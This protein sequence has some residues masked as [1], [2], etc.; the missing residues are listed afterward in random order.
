MSYE[1]GWLQRRDRGAGPT[2][3]MTPEPAEAL[4]E[5][6]GKRTLVEHGRGAA[7]DPAGTPTPTVGKRTLV[8]DVRGAAAHGVSG[9]SVALPYLDQIQ[10]SFGR[11]DVGHVRA[12]VGGAAA[13]G[14]AAMG[15]D[16][17]AMGDHVAFAGAPDLHTAAHEAAH[18]VQQRGGVQLRGGVG[19]VGDAYEQ[20]ADAVADLVVQGKSS[21]ALLDRHAG[22]GGP[23]GA[24]GA[25]AIQR[26]AFVKGTQVLNSDEVAVDKVAT[27]VTDDLVRNYDSKEELQNHAA[28]Q[29]D[30]LGNLNGGPANG[31]WLRFFP[32]GT[33]VLGESHELVPLDP[34][35]A[36]VGSRSFI[37]ER[38]ATDD[39]V[40]GS[41][42]EEVY[43]ADNAGR[44]ASFGIQD[45]PDK[46][47]Y[48]AEPL[49]PKFGFVLI[50]A[51]G[52]FDKSKA[53]SGL[54]SP[55]YAG[56]PYQRYLK[57]AWAHAVGCKVDVAKALE[58]KQKVPP[59]L[60]LMV[61]AV[62]TTRAALD[63]FIPGL[64]VDGYLGDSIVAAS[65]LGASGVASVEKARLDALLDAL[66][67]FTTA[68]VDAVVEYAATSGKS[69][70]DEQGQKKFSGPT[71]QE[72]KKGLF[73]DWRNSE[74]AKT[75]LA[76]AKGGIR[77]AGMGRKH[78]EAMIEKGLPDHTHPFD[79]VE[80]DLAAFQVETEKLR[81]K[82]V[83]Q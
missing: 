33:N 45:E 9:P 47:K 54:K 66:L 20:H 4:R 16:A 46:K 22:L 50:D 34:V 68:Y 81:Q 67:V 14:A 79:M 77:Y 12:H 82:A 74:F 2:D 57:M 72:D 53:L 7:H 51:I 5:T 80:K 17:F 60:V 59:K 52:Y 76:A 3:G 37:H 71:T 39:L 63:G 18:V 10:R 43:S 78:Y 38:I 62:D 26:H 19:E 30:Y 6:V 73:K 75:L 55:N 42:L 11:H 24:T 29:T 13:H 32:G 1:R 25:T 58:N 23:G 35:L 41:K 61:A 44:F 65:K 27:F 40:K 15:A 28:G 83:K 56:K 31:T 49:L 36:A 48:G 69:H 64:V 8:E 21:E 70:L